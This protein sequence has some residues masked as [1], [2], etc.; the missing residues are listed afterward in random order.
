[1]KDIRE[2]T[3]G[4]SPLLLCFLLLMA[5]DKPGTSPRANADETPD[6]YVG[7]IVTVNSSS[8]NL[9][10]APGPFYLTD[11]SL[12]F[13]DSADL[14][15][16]AGT[17][18]GADRYPDF[19]RGLLRWGTGTARDHHGMRVLVHQGEVLCVQSSEEKNARL[20]WAGFRPF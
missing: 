3:L 6:R 1:M 4:Q 9:L 19:G 5:C 18:C 17:D 10:L 16:Q 15:V 7:G 13:G 2:R 14:F 11:A 20:L 12:T 8:K